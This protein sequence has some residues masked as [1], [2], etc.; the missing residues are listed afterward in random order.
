M[1][2]GEGA[3]NVDDGLRAL[4]EGRGDGN[5]RYLSAVF[6]ALLACRTEQER[7]RL[8]EAAVQIAPDA[9]SAARAYRVCVNQKLAVLAGYVGKTPGITKD[10]LDEWQAEARACPVGYPV[11]RPADTERR[12]DESYDIKIVPA[13]NSKIELAEHPSKWFRKD[14]QLGL[15]HAQEII[16]DARFCRLADLDGRLGEQLRTVKWLQDTYAPLD[17]GRDRARADAPELRL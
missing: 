13:K 3:H 1:L 17:A 6:N 16:G 9:R 2:P 12:G 10:K 7:M 8:L 15:E 4:Q 14:L 5:T 11:P